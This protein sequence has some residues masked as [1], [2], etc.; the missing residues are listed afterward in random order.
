MTKVKKYLRII[1]L[2][3]LL[4]ESIISKSSYRLTTKAP[5]KVATT[6]QPEKSL[7]NPFQIIPRATAPPVYTFQP[8]FEFEGVDY[9]A[10]EHP[11]NKF[12]ISG[13]KRMNYDYCLWTLT[14]CIRSQTYM[15]FICVRNTTSGDDTFFVSHCEYEYF[16]CVETER[17]LTTRFRT[18]TRADYT[19]ICP[20][21]DLNPLHAALRLL[22]R[23]VLFLQT[24][25]LSCTYALPP[26]YGGVRGDGGGP[27]PPPWCPYMIFY[28]GWWG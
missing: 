10:E 4:P 27:P 6:I 22:R 11:R 7:Y 12:G 5:R 18:N 17:K 1:C 15:H 8:Y 19:K 2:C 13:K 23:A 24:D 14:S 26:A 21:W 28:C 9:I 20:R 16:N 3:L 25:G